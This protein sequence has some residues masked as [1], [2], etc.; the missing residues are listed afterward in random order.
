MKK[1]KFISITPD[2]EFAGKPKYKIINTKSEGELGILFYHKPWK[3]Y[4]FTQS[5]QGVIFNK[6]CLLDIIDFIE[7]KLSSNTKEEVFI[8]RCAEINKE[9]EILEEKDLINTNGNS[10]TEYWIEIS[11]KGRKMRFEKE[12]VFDVE[13]R[14]RTWRNNI[15]K[16]DKKFVKETKLVS[17][18][19]N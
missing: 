7:T 15:D 9:F 4:V 13:R 5:Q 17:C 18:R 10:F 19:R 2:G 3:Q 14:L 8:N 12:S 6:S 11:F 16:Y 1:Y